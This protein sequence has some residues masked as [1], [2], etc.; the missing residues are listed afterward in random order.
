MHIFV[1]HYTY[2]LIKMHIVCTFYFTFSNISQISSID[3]FEILLY[4][5]LIGSRHK[6]LISC[7]LL[8]YRH[9]YYLVSLYPTLLCVISF[10]TETIVKDNDTESVIIIILIFYLNLYVMLEASSYVHVLCKSE[11]SFNC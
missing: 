7:Q 6:T 5:V 3:E 11:I 2:S 8:E 4:Y 10:R 1:I 9:Y